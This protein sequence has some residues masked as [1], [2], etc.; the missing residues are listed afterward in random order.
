MI[1]PVYHHDDE[2]AHLYACRVHDMVLDLISSLA[3]EDNFVTILNGISDNNSFEGKVRRMSLQN[4]AKEEHQ[5]M[6]L[7]SVSTSQV[8]SIAAFKHAIALM[9]S[10]SSFVVLHVLDLTGCDLRGHDHH[11]NLRELGCLLHLRYLGLALTKICELPEEVGKLQFLQ[12]LDLRGNDGMELPSSVIKLRRLMCLIIDHD[13]KRLPH[14]LGNMTSIE[15]LDQIHGDSLITVKEL[16]NLE[17][18]RKLA[19]RFRYLSLE[20]EEAF[21]ES[22]GKLSNIQSVRILKEVNDIHLMDHLGERWVPP[23]SLREFIM[24]GGARFSIMPAWIRRNPSHMSQVSVLEIPVVKV[25]QEDLVF[26]GRLPALRNLRLNSFRRQSELLL[27]GADGFCSL[28]SFLLFFRFPGH[29][30]FQPGAMPKVQTVEFYH[31]LRVA[32]DEEAAGNVG[33]WFDLG[34]ENLPS[35]RKVEVKFLRSG[36]KVGEAKQAEA[37]LRKSLRTHPNRPTIDICINPGIPEDAHDDD[38]YLTD[39]EE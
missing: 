35:L 24:Y 6:P 12:V 23:R 27:V 37:A 5:T 4:V 15:V 33:D 18:L 8:R 22:L 3:R 36:V 25:R 10:L 9:P 11:L 31:C 26:L 19:I 28:S 2:N 29:I 34:M 39:D 32:R 14:G 21:V 13:H 16:G 30:V 20:L 17:R 7:K 1:Q 38:I